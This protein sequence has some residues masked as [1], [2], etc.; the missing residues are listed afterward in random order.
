MSDRSNLAVGSVSG[1]VLGG[2]SGLLVASKKLKDGIPFYKEKFF[3]SRLKDAST[4]LQGKQLQEAADTF[5]N[6]SKEL[7]KEYSDLISSIKTALKVHWVVPL[8]VAGL[9]IGT[10]TA[11]IINKVKASKAQ[12]AE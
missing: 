4:D 10:A 9:A 11:A 1:G 6:S 7:T 12:K 3:V 2:A 5:I 8:A